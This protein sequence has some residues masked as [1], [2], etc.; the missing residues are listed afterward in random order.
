M[1]KGK[2]IKSIVDIWDVRDYSRFEN[3][4]GCGY[5]KNEENCNIHDPTINKAKLGC[6]DWKHYLENKN[7]SYKRALSR[8]DSS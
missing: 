6:K 3:Q 4:V 7:G 1:E 2:T 8:S 5:C